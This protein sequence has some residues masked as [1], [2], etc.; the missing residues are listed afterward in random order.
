MKIV[1][2]IKETKSEMKHVSWPTRR[3]AMAFT[4]IVIAI[5]VFVAILLGLF[6]Y[7]FTL[8]IEKFIA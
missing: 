2:Y 6:D 7:L 1:E 8:G 4:A 3:Q 5:S